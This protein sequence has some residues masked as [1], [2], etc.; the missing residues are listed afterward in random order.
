MLG[1]V[2]E[3]VSKETVMK[4]LFLSLSLVVVFALPALAQDKEADRVENAGKAMKEILPAT[5]D[6]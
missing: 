2:N 3:R 1:S 6:L 4:N 5:A